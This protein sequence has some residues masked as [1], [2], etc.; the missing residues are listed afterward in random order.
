MNTKQI[1]INT[2]SYK[3][4][5]KETKIVLHGPMMRVCQEPRS[6]INPILCICDSFLKEEEGVRKSIS[7]LQRK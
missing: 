1:N 3:P 6:L 5:S 7:K 2:G 4:V